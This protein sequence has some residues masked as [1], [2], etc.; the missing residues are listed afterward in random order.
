MGNENDGV[1]GAAVL[2][3]SEIKEASNYNMNEKR[4]EQCHGLL[5]ALMNNP[6]ISQVEKDKKTRETT[7]SHQKNSRQ[8][9]L[10]T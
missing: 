2:E 9:T 4:D 1:G 3:S 8:T 5:N 6:N 7:S 10:D